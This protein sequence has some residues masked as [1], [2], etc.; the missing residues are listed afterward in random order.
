MKRDVVGRPEMQELI[1]LVEHIKA[2]GLLGVEQGRSDRKKD[3][4]TK[5]AAGAYALKN[6]LEQIE[7]VA[8]NS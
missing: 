8:D 7:Q 5:L 2:R 4:R 1:K 3:L 6:A